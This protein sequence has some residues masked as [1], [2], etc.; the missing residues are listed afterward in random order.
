MNSSIK[1]IYYL[2]LSCFLILS[3]NDNDEEDPFGNED[4]Q[5]RV[6]TYAVNGNDITLVTDFESNSTFYADQTNHQELWDFFT[7]LIPLSARGEFVEYEL[8]ADPDDDTEAYVSPVDP[9]DLSQWE[10]GYNMTTVWSSTLEFQQSRVAY[11]SIHEYAHVMTLNNT[12]VT[13]GGTED[14]CANFFPGEGCST[15]SSYINQFFTNYWTDI[16][17]ESQSFDVDDDDA[18]FAFYDKYADRFVT[19]Y[20]STNPGEDIAESFTEFVLFDAPTGD[21]MKDDKVRFFYNYQELVDLRDAIR[22]NIDFQIDIDQIGEA[23]MDRL[24]AERQ[25]IY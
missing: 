24:R 19:E 14:N 6:A 21:Q 7:N 9:S 16:Y 12:Q 2:L 18:F 20:A 23:R 5:G 22:S 11:N 25:L 17:D 15:A 10:V 4:F 3:C 13:V 8:F 1:P